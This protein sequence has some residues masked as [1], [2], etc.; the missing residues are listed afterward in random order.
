MRIFL[1]TTITNRITMKE[2]FS[3]NKDKTVLQK[4]NRDL[5]ILER[6]I[7]KNCMN[8]ITKQIRS[9]VASL[10]NQKQLTSSVPDL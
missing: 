8:G 1:A 7:M 4:R 5:R 6:Y 2:A 10:K 9:K 3:D